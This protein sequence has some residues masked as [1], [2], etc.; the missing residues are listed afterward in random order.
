MI[1]K[2]C[3]TFKQLQAIRALLLNF[4]GKIFCKTINILHYII[5]FAPGLINSCQWLAKLEASSTL[6]SHVDIHCSA[7]VVR[8]DRKKSAERGG[9]GLKGEHLC[10]GGKLGPLQWTAWNLSPQLGDFKTTWVWANTP[11]ERHAGSEASFY[12]P[13][14][15]DLSCFRQIKHT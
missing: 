12:P 14:P 9:H 2:N 7:V 4:S 10:K 5:Y 15:G 6:K 8:P 13:A 11:A 1:I 3:H